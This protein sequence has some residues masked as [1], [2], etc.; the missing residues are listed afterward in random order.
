MDE[1]VVES[2][3][4][5]RAL[6]GLGM[7]QEEVEKDEREAERG[8]KKEGG[9]EKGKGREKERKREGERGK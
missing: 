1:R 7:A 6:M 4:R 8:R 2:C 3:W 5:S 9:R